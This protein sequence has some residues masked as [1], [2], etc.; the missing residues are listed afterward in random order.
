MSKWKV[1]R[2]L[3]QTG[4][5]T[6]RANSYPGG[7]FNKEGFV[8]K[9]MRNSRFGQVLIEALESR[10]SPA[11]IS[12]TTFAD[13]GPGSLRDAINK[14]NAAA[15]D[16]DIVFIAKKGTVKLQSSLPTITDDLTIS[17]G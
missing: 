16:D 9:K 1:A 4:V 13:S 15:G 17:T 8:M 11:T 6:P 14:A 2:L 7:G 3:G 5:D 10:I 12:V